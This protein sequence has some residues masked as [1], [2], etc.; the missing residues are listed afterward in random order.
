MPLRSFRLLGVVAALSSLAL[1]LAVPAWAAPSPDSGPTDGGT[2]VSFKVSERP[3][4]FTQLAAGAFGGAALDVDGAAFA[5]GENGSG[6]L[7]TGSED[8]SSFVPV[9]AA[10]P[11]D[12]F[13][14]ITTGGSHTLALTPDGAVYSWGYGG[15]GALGRT[16]GDSRI[17]GLVSA[18]DEITTISAGSGH[19]L[20]LDSAG[21]VYSWGLNYWGQLGDD[22]TNQWRPLPAAVPLPAG[23]VITAISAGNGHSLALDEAGNAW[24]WGSNESGALG[25]GSGPANF[26][27]PVKVSMPIGVTFTAVAAGD[28]HSLALGSDG[29]TYSW[30][31]NDSGQLGV[32]SDTSSTV[33]V[34]VPVQLPPGITFTS[35]TAGYAHSLALGSDGETYAWGLNGSGQLGD[36]STTES[37]VPIPVELPDG[38]SFTQ[39]SARTLWSLALGSDGN[40]YWWGGVETELGLD[41][42]LPTR[43]GLGVEVDEVLF[44]QTAGADLT[45][46]DSGWSVTSPAHACGPVDLTIK[47]TQLGRAYTDEIEDGFTFGTAPV[48]TGSPVSA[49]IAAGE[50][51]VATAAASGDS[52]PAV[53]W[54]R[55]VGGAAWTNVSGATQNTLTAR[56]DRTT[57]FR[58]VFSNCLGTATS[59]VAVATVE[60]SG[61]T[62]G[63]E[64]EPGGSAGGGSSVAPE[65]ISSPESTPTAEV[66]TVPP[67][68]AEPTADPEPSNVPEPSLPATPPV[69][70]DQPSGPVG[71]GWLLAVLA[72]LAAGGGYWWW[73]VRRGPS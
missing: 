69:A 38:V 62:S 57:R 47:F 40:A 12:T 30:G 25:N 8:Y 54:Q 61:G 68:T 49:T 27:P 53:Q 28:S 37:T 43:L 23:T 51:F 39:I 34:P 14:A 64:N 66:P 9:P 42:L 33:P 11:D 52:V 18:I 65:E 16:G 22:T 50:L 1:G 73:R 60:S 13:S 6:E 44:D 2:V 63:G 17:P 20:A 71:L 26:V 15:R 19:S 59:A 32:G 35:I 36:G 10:M 31:A 58:A 46:G 29:K 24:A 70:P 4:G 56:V 7:G 48:V 5:W 55:S 67:P 41:T 72:L 45:A 21:V 3:A